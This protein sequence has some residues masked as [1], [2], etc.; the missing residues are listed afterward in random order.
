MPGGDRGIVAT[1]APGGL[2]N[3]RLRCLC[4]WQ[5]Q[6]VKVRIQT[7]A[8][9]IVPK[10]PGKGGRYVHVRKTLSA[11]ALSSLPADGCRTVK[12]EPFFPVF[13]GLLCPPF[14]GPSVR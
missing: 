13:A 11:C 3:V 4:L 5:Y 7:R 14:S 8:S 1:V 9:S 2:T 10:V 12:P 6:R